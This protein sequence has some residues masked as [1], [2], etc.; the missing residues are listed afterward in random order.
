M[1]EGQFSGYA[2][3][4]FA[5]N[6]PFSICIDTTLSLHADR[7]FSSLKSL[8]VFSSRVLKALAEAAAFG[9]EGPSNACFE[10]TLRT[11]LFPMLKTES[12][13]QP[14][15]TFFSVLRHGRSAYLPRRASVVSAFSEAL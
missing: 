14:S 3:H 2:Y 12:L 1:R 5:L 4:L 7:N 10:F 15:G 8:F 9:K 13:S 11:V 6:R